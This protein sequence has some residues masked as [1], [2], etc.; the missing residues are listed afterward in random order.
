MLVTDAVATTLTK[1]GEPRHAET[2]RSGDIREHWP[3]SGARRRSRDYPMMKT[4]TIADSRGASESRKNAIP[5]SIAYST[6]SAA[7][8]LNSS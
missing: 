5:S 8:S 7:V 4:A 1:L 3:Q 6:P 2:P